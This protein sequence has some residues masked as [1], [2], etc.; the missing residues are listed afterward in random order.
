MSNQQQQQQLPFSCYTLLHL[1]VPE[2]DCVRGRN[3]VR[4]INHPYDKI[5]ELCRLTFVYVTF[6]PGTFYECLF[7]P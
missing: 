2:V 6:Y 3:R 7:I 4:L 5:D 1:L